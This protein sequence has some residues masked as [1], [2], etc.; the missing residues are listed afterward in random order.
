MMELCSYPSEIVHKTSLFLQSYG[1][2]KSLEITTTP[3]SFFRCGINRYFLRILIKNTRFSVTFVR[4]TSCAAILS[5][6]VMKS[7]QKG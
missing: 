3:P 1:Y 6:G 7:W 5:C 4:F 2:C